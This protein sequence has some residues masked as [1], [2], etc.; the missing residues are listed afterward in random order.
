MPITAS[1]ADVKRLLAQLE[2][3]ETVMFFP[4]RNFVDADGTPRR[5]SPGWIA[6]GETLV[7]LP[8][9]DRSRE[10]LPHELAALIELANA[11]E[12]RFAAMA[13]PVIGRLAA[14]TAALPTFQLED[15]KILG[16]LDADYPISAFQDG[17]SQG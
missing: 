8:G 14:S 15:G 13:A 11:G 2:T 10:L 1:D 16:P 5:G 3:T 6:R 4:K 7:K 17:S 9:E 12:V